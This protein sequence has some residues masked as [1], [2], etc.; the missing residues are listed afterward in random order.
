MTLEPDDEPI[1][2]A[3][4]DLNRLIIERVRREQRR[5]QLTGLSNDLALDEFLEQHLERGIDIWAAFIEVD[6][7]KSINDQFGYQNADELLKSLGRLLKDFSRGFPGAVD[8]TQVFRP[9]GDEFFVVGAHDSLNPHRTDVLSS[10]LDLAC[11]KVGALSLVVHTPSTAQAPGRLSCT[12]SIGWLV[13]GD[14]PPPLT[15]RAVRDCLERAVDEAKRTRNCA[16]RYS[17]ALRHRRSVS[18]RADCGSCRSKFT[19]DIPIDAN[20]AG[21]A[22]HCPNCSEAAAHPPAP[23]EVPIKSLIEL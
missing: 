19:V 10:L 5:D 18:L 14:V 3:L 20:R 13:S 4:A 23:D 12:V 2:A 9:H 17:S 22:L 1:R 7:F 6:K 8:A 15:A 21:A 16:V 11:T